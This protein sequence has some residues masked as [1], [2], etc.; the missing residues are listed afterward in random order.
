M[1]ILKTKVEIRDEIAVTDLRGTPITNMEVAVLPCADAEGRQLDEVD[2][3]EAPEQLV[4]RNVY[5]DF[6]LNGCRSLPS[7]FKVLNYSA[8]KPFNEYILNFV[9]ETGCTLQIPFLWRQ[10]GQYY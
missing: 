10:D 7:K 3:I 8:H 1:V 4:G 6:R 2:L 9:Y 5:L